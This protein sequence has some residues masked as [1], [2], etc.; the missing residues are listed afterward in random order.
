VPLR[1]SEVHKCD[2]LERVRAHD[3]CLCAN[4]DDLV[5]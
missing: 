2:G 1:I 4:D 5:Q 3:E